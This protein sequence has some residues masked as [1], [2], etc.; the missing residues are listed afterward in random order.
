MGQQQS[1]CL[2]NKP[3]N[4]QSQVLRMW[5]TAV[6]GVLKFKTK[7]KHTATFSSNGTQKLQ[8]NERGHSVKCLSIFFFTQKSLPLPRCQTDPVFRKVLS[9]GGNDCG[10]VVAS[11]FAEMW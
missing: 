1:H 2:I 9:G 11:D 3:A 6:R 10:S 7:N 4:C 5:G 8:V